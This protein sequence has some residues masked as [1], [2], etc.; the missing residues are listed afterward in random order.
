M[1]AAWEWQGLPM[2]EANSVKDSVSAAS[3]ATKEDD[4]ALLRQMGYKQELR[5][6]LSGF[7]NFAVSFTVV[8]VL[9]GLTGL[10]GLGFTYGGPVAII[11]GWPVVSFFTLLVALSMAEICSAYPTSGALYFWSAKL[12]GPRWAPLASWVTGWFNL[13]GQMAV[14]AGID[15]TFAAFLST[16]ITLGTG[17]VNGE[18]PFVATQSQLLGIYAGTLVCHGLLNT[19][20]NRLLAILNGISVFWHVVGTFVFIVALLAVAP[21]HQSASYVFGHF[22]KPDVG[23][24]SSGLI[25]L[26]G[27]LMS[28]FTLT[29]YDASAHM[30]EETKDAAKSGPRGI[31]M[32]VVVSFFVGWLYLLA[33]TFSIQN[34]DN[35]FDPASAT[36]GTYASAQV[37]WDASAARYGDGERS[38]ALMII[39]LMG[40]FF[41]GMASITSNSRMLYAF[42]R[43]GAVPG[44]RWWHHINPHTKT[45]VN[46]V[47]LSVVVAFLLGL[48]VLD[49]AVVFTAVTSI[50]TIG[51]YISYVVPVFLR[52]T[53]ARATFVRGPFHLGRLSLPIGITA[54]LWVVFV[55]CIFVLPTVYPVTKDNL[56]YAGVAVGVVL[57]FSL[58]WWFLPYKGARHWFHGPIAQ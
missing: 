50:A 4:E 33:L 21:T 19:F 1:T 9:T 31:V 24:A 27:L 32:T 52:C 43:D 7:H 51:L 14:T 13:L 11:W 58:G 17:G 47:W 8:S 41:C 56:N 46:A 26:L 5:R 54:V 39:P 40:Q 2:A 28:Q 25:F 12:A 37:I 23:I 16:I 36:G 3:L 57:V 35:L 30:T 45:P 34:P 22:N 6:G 18:D 15:F 38:I 49:S 29:G 55:S 44:S 48:P 10:Y 42:S 20:A 53:V